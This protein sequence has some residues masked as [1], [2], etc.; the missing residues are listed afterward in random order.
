MFNTKKKCWILLLCNNWLKSRFRLKIGQNLSPWHGAE[1]GVPGW[2]NSVKMVLVGLYSVF[3]ISWKEQKRNM[4]YM[5]S[6]AHYTNTSSIRSYMSFFPL[7]HILCC[8]W[9]A[10]HEKVIRVVITVLDSCNVNTL[11]TLNVYIHVAGSC[12]KGSK[13]ITSSCLSVQPFRNFCSTDNFLVIQGLGFYPCY[14]M[15]VNILETLHLCVF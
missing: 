14:M 2:F 10:L 1:S 11:S 8:K 3:A 12:Q 9:K 7:F 13:W 5:L 4:L 6:L 15:M